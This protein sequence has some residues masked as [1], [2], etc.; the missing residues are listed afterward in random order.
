MSI[1]VVQEVTNV[2]VE[3]E[4]FTVT[5]TSSGITV[6]PTAKEVTVA[7]LG[8]PGPEGPTGPAGPAGAG[9]R[10][11]HTQ[12]AP[13]SDITITHSLGVSPSIVTPVDTN[14]RVIVMEVIHVDVNTVQLLPSPPFSGKVYIAA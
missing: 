7:T 11:E 2:T 5:P 4:N 8:I 12:G 14:G 6:A 13:S 9:A 1:N 3:T 10:Y